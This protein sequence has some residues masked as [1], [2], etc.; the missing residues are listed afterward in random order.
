[1]KYGHL[2]N[3][4]PE[5]E[6]ERLMPHMMESHILHIKQCKL[7]AESAHRKHMKELNEH[8]KNIEHSLMLLTPF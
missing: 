3:D 7:K 5:A 8:I 6:R 4:L 1:M 2:W